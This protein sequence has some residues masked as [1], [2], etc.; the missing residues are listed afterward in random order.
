MSE[1]L[2]LAIF[3]ALIVIAWYFSYLLVRDVKR[4][5]QFA[6][7]TCIVIVTCAVSGVFIKWTAWLLGKVV[8]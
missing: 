1:V 3:L 5:E 8:G 6:S 2:V 7:V 4:G